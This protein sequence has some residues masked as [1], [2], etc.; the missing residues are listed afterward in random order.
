MSPVL[1][2][3]VDAPLRRLFD[4]RPPPDVE[5]ARLRPGVRLWVPFG[6]RRAV[7]V[8]VGLREQ[9]DLPVAKLKAAL[10]LIDEEPV[11]DAALLEL[12]RW[13]AEYYRHPPGEVIAAALPGPLRSGAAAAQTEETWALSAAARAGELEPIA[14]RARRLREVLA[15]LEGRAQ[16]GAAEFAPLSPRWREHVR[17]LERRGWLTR[18]RQDL[19]AAAFSGGAGARRGVAPQPT[20]E[21]HD[22][23]GAIEAARGRFAS[24][25]LHG[26]TGSGKTEVYLRAIEAAVARGEQALVLVPEIALT[27]QL[28]ERFAARFAA[29]L[30]VL[31]S[32]LAE[33]ERLAAWRAARSGAA[34]VV[35]GTRSAIFAPL[36]RPGL[37]IVDE[38]HDPS[39]KQQEGFRYSAR[40]LALVR[41]Q[42]LGIPVVLGSAT[43]SLESLERA[44]AGRST[45]LVLP[46]RTAGARP[47]ELH[48]IDLRRHGETQGIATPT[49]LTMQRHLAGGGQVLL[50]LNRRGYA[51]TLFCPACGWIAPCPRCDAR[52]TVHRREH[53]LH[54][55]HCGTEQPVPEFCP[56]CGEAVKPVGQGTERVEET[57]A[58]HFPGV[59][60]ERIDRDAVRRRGSLEEAL[61]RIQRGEV[62]ILV[63]TQMLTKGHHFPEVSL[64]VVLNADQGLF[65]TDFRSAER[66][67][68]TIVQVAG[69]AGRA[70]RAGE[71]L[72]QTEYPEHPLLAQLVAGGYDAFA[73]AALE[74]RREARWPPFARVA[75]LR[76]EAAER[77]R[78]LAF[79]DAARALAESLAEPGVEVLGPAAAPM[80][81][82]AGHFRAQLLV[83]ASGHAPLQRLLARWIP[84]IEADPEARRV[85]WSIDVDPLELF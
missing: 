58:Q 32:S 71:V 61:G 17:E 12:L 24:F 51:P 43:P 47:P 10:A 60:L 81:R 49:L 84:A 82:R 26:V 6:R 36:A 39:Y 54:C 21:Q 63:G 64:V 9:S 42:R 23:L 48:L 2:I 27:P 83:H 4:Y 72:I 15:A 3:A 30:A 25:L 44:R 76:A 20:A 79:L 73:E 22:A 45:L 66:L 74:E 18:Q 59:A 68:Q 8:L 46:N 57:L 78:P 5:A 16:A 75:V 77:T 1:V 65:S 53:A 69:R 40:D 33:G 55:H 31:H 85:R 67:A 19:M 56:D 34:P 50:Y 37:I 38:E 52:L 28:V 70:E 14:A 35:I 41:A 29:P 80:E 7:G 62:R 11:L 13:S